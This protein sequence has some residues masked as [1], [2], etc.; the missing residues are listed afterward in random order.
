GKL[1]HLSK[2]TPA[3]ELLTLLGPGLNP[4]ESGA[5]WLG[6]VEYEADGKAQVLLPFS[7][8][9]TASVILTDGELASL[10]KVDLP[11]EDYRLG[12]GVLISQETLLPGYEADIAVRPALSL[13]GEPVPLS[14]IDDA[15][16]TVTTTD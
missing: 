2:T 6:G 14:K 16:L 13:H 5:A 10:V 4:V 1:E 15:T 3:G 8:S 11:T 7:R 12:L 9:G